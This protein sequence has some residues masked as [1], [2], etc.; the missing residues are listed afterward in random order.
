MKHKGISL[1]GGTLGE[2]RTTGFGVKITGTEIVM[3]LGENPKKDFAIISQMYPP[4]GK[5]TTL[6]QVLIN[7]DEAERLHRSLGL[8]LDA[9]Y[10]K[11]PKGSSEVLV[12]RFGLTHEECSEMYKIIHFGASIEEAVDEYLSR[13]PEE[14][15]PRALALALVG[16]NE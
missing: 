9:Y 3:K 2:E 14:V 1:S 7:I 10:H 8:A 6:E 16:V 13:Y 12:E 4:D 5:D 15:R 11:L